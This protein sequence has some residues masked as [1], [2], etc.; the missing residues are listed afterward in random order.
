[1]SN[2]AFPLRALDPGG[3]KHRCAA[4]I[5]AQDCGCDRFVKRFQVPRTYSE[6]FSTLPLVG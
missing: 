1:M 3:L 2:G 4:A 5:E 6:F